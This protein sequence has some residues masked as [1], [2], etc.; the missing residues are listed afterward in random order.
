MLPF[1][2]ASLSRSC[3]Y[4]S[5][6]SVPPQVTPGERVEHKSRTRRPAPAAAIPVSALEH[7]RSGLLVL[8]GPGRFPVV[9]LSVS[10]D[11]PRPFPLFHFPQGPPFPHPASRPRGRET[12]RSSF[13]SK[14]SGP[15]LL[16]GTYSLQ[17][18]GNPSFSRRTVYETSN[19]I[20]RASLSIPSSFRDL[21]FFA[22]FPS[23]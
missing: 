14:T 10:G 13:I 22:L 15:L 16:S 18:F 2:A 19:N 17:R 6:C 4:S 1:A 7:W 9:L 23:N 8:S 3:R 11:T 12:I 21:D 20:L 5:G